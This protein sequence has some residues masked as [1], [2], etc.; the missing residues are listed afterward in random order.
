MANL[1]YKDYWYNYVF[2]ANPKDIEKVIT[3]KDITSEGKRI[4]LNIYDD[5]KPRDKTMIFV[6]GTS[7]YSRFYAEFCYNLF[8]KGFRVVAPD[9]TGHGVS[10]GVRGHFKMVNFC[11]NIYDLTS[12]VIEKYG[13]KVGIMGSSL[14][15]ITSLYCAANDERLKAV[16]CH[17][18][19]IFNEKFYKQITKNKLSL[20]ILIPLVPAVAKIAP[21]M[22][23][24][25][26]MYLDFYKLA[27]SKEV[28]DIIDILLNDPLLSLKYSATSI[29]TQMR[30]PLAKPIEN[31]KT[32]IMIID[33]DEDVLFSV[34][35]MTEIFNRLTCKNKRLEILKGASHLIYQENIEESLGRI[36]PWLEKML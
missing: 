34:E 16:I 33:G 12:Y 23:F 17:N 7:V 9:L 6:H 32:P 5:D 10:E 36:V 35:S 11:Q 21:K 4:H 31:I 22:K 27:K 2:K 15:G 19:A 14:G 24:S 29:K 13:E 8:K 1:E 20:K 18:A 3:E 28:L 30:E 25:V 26:L